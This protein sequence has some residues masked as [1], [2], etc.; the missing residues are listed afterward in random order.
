MKEAG[1]EGLHAENDF[2]G[3]FE[4]SQEIGLGV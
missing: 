3:Q 4:Y 1:S 2:T